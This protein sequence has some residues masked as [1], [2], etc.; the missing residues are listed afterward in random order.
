MRQLLDLPSCLLLDLI[1]FLEVEDA[2]RLSMTCRLLHNLFENY[3]RT[4]WIATLK[5]TC[6]TRPLP[7][8]S[9]EDIT[10]YDTQAVL[11]LARHFNRLNYNWKQERPQ[12]VGRVRTL[13]VDKNLDSIAQI[14][15]TPYVITHSI[16][17]CR[18]SVSSMENG[19]RLCSIDADRRV[20]DLSTGWPEHGKFTIALLTH[21]EFFLE[22]GLFIRV[23]TVDYS[24]PKVTMNI[25][26][27]T[28]LESSDTR[29]YRAVFLNADVVGVLYLIDDDDYQLRFHVLAF[30][31]KT[32]QST[33]IRVSIGPYDPFTISWSGHIGTSFWNDNLYILY[34]YNRTPYHSWIP[35]NMLPYSE[36]TDLPSQVTYNAK[37]F[38]R[39]EGQG[40]LHYLNEGILTT[41]ADFGIIASTV[42][43]FEQEHKKPVVGIDFWVVDADSLAEAEKSG[44][45]PIPNL[46][47]RVTIPG[48]IR[49]KNPS[50]WCLYQS[51]NSGLYFVVALEDWER[52]PKIAV[53]HFQL[54]D[55]RFTVHEIEAPP[56]VK[57][58]QVSGFFIDER[59]GTIALYISKGRMFVMK[60]A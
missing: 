42:Y 41:K 52:K 49:T 50:T 31:R 17:K 14:A 8:P 16:L 59:L 2:T 47:P 36:N 12:V 57:A 25:T 58:H 23:L 27:E 3:E 39:E 32:G 43:T 37:P 60:Y 51:T 7:C 26:F 24:G 5:K 11:N 46:Y 35:K 56:Y 28:N 1:Q 55:H 9:H 10:K 30:N 19:K 53:V 38:C 18:L 40:R 34:E 44:T 6:Q 20:S 45:L 33:D 48:T 13:T 22:D 21:F 29:H 4:F 15:G 54:P